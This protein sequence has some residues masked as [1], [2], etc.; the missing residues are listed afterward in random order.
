[1]SVHVYVFLLVVGLFLLLM[2]LWRLD[3]LPL[4]PSHSRGGAKLSFSRCQ[5]FRQRHSRSHE[6][7]TQIA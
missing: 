2:P 5:I 1:M 4:R 6:Y 7:S 3:W